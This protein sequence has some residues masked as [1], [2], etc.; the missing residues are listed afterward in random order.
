MYQVTQKLRYDQPSGVPITT[1]AYSCGHGYQ[2]SVGQLGS[3]TVVHFKLKA[4]QGGFSPDWHAG[5]DPQR[6]PKISAEER[7]AAG[8]QV[9]EVEKP[10]D[11]RIA[12]GFLVGLKN[13]FEISGCLL[14]YHP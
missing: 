2:T 8:P 11:Q 6:G 1:T 14:N 9:L 13:G 3:A 10:M 12:D 5:A 4:I 7:A